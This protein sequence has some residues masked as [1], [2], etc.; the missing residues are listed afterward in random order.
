MTGSKIDPESFLPLRPLVF[1]IL[2]LLKKERL[3]GYSI[4]KKVNDNAG[5]RVVLGP[6]T[7]YRTLKEMRDV[8]L[9]DHA[10][11][12]RADTDDR[13]SYYMLTPLGQRVV[14]AEALRI[15]Q[16]LRDARLASSEG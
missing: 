6:G 10:Q 4:M 7:L 2:L 15:G 9:V 3:H 1:S 13:R 12:P 11:P 14:R 8:G 16:L 5:K